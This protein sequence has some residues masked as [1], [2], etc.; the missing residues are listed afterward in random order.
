VTHLY[1]KA[2]HAEQVDAVKNA[3]LVELVVNVEVLV[4]VF[5]AEYV[6]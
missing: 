1:I 6:Q 3:G 2:H 4:E 5:P